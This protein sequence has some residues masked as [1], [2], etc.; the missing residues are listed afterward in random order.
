[1]NKALLILG[2]NL[3]FVIAMTSLFGD[4]GGYWQVGPS[5]DLLVISLRINTWPRYIGL[6][7]CMSVL[8]GS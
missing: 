2:L 1:M 5:D 3:M 8:K 6:L 4:G 7:S